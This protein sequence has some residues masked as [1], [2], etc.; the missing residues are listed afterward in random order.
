MRFLILGAAVLT[1][2]AC[3]AEGQPPSDQEIEYA[4][5]SCAAYGFQPGTN[6]MAQCVSTFIKDARDNRRSK[7]RAIGQSMQGYGNS[8]QA[9]RPLTTRCTRIG[10]QLH[11]SSY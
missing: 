6:E 4:S 5:K 10:N 7:L 11:C 8:V 3:V 9:N 1:L 2:S